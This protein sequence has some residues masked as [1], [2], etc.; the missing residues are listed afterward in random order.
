MLDTYRAILVHPGARA[1]ALAGLLARLPISMFNISMILM[2]QI[3]YDSYAIA[4]RV[5]AVGVLVW[6]LQTVPTARLVDRIGQ[7]AAMIPLTL[8][9]VGGATLAIVTAMSGGPEWL[10]WVAVAVA[11]IQGP[12]GSL[13]RARWSHLLSS[14][15]DIH[16][17]FS[18]EG[19]LDEV[20]FVAGPALATVLATLVWPPLGV[21][22]CLV[23][24]VTGMTILLAQRSTEPAARRGTGG[25]SLGLRLPGPVV[26]VSL[27]ALGL[28]A[29][30]GA[31]D[32]SV[33]AFADEA[34]HKTL[35]GLVIGIISARSLVGGL[36]YGARHWR[37]PLW[38]RTVLGALMLA[39]GFGALALAPNLLVLSALGFVA[40]LAIA[41][42]LTNADTV[43][44]RVVARDQITEG[45]AWLRI[46]VGIGISAGA[47]IAGGLIEASGARAG[48]ATA[49]AGA[50]AALV[51]AIA[52]SG[53]L[54]RGTE[55]LGRAAVDDAL[56]PSERE[57]PVEQ[58]PTPPH[59]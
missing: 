9:F 7:R 35:A 46:G 17:A 10:L 57:R 13:T 33:V 39:C 28:G 24:L 27:L 22:V 32:I 21:V 41:P 43:V 52:S 20:L 59:M 5:A 40:G 25:R 3:Q 34:G 55:R 54:R 44:Q 30:F 6:A 4:G 31:F 56:P 37:A 49:A 50:G 53:V 23:G 18:L 16:T 47:W 58:P 51:L 15:T 12:L 42:T 2:V 48:L 38:K 14:D 11:S 19:A 26:A 8:T 1:F 45:M 36:L 29:M